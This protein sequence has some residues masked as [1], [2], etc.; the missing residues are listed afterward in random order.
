MANGNGDNT[1]IR[2]DTMVVC[3]LEITILSEASHRYVQAPAGEN[4]P[5]GGRYRLVTRPRSRP[6]EWNGNFPVIVSVT[7]VTRYSR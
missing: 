3:D 4:G 7:S 5:N 6:P 2:V 1:A